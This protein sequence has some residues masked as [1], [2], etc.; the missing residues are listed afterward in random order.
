MEIE[1]NARSHTLIDEIRRSKP[2][3]ADKTDAEITEYVIE[4]DLKKREADQ[5]KRGFVWR[6]DG[7]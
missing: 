5:N 6:R 1:L 4:W 3:L 2:E 7:R